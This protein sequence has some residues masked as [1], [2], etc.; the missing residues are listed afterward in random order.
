MFRRASALT[1]SAL[2][3]LNENTLRQHTESRLRTGIRVCLFCCFFCWFFFC[4]EQFGT[5]VGAF[6]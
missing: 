2:E 4:Q 5:A 3:I 1:E 6:L